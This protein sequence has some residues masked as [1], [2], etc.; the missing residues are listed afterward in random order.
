MY[1]GIRV[2]WYKIGGYLRNPIAGQNEDCFLIDSED[3]D[4]TNHPRT[5][6][7]PN[8]IFRAISKIY[9]HFHLHRAEKKKESA[10]DRAATSTARATWAIA[11][12][13]VVTIGVGVSQYVIFSRQLTVMQGQLNAMDADQRPWV[14]VFPKDGLS[15][16]E[17]LT[18]DTKNGATMRIA[19]KLRNTGKS[20]GLRPGGG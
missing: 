6:R 3:S 13:T 10:A 14:S 19:Y 4:Q 5:Q 18:F 16:I 1:S 15:I 20:P 12:L 7:K 2:G 17:P 9:S 8:W 11:F